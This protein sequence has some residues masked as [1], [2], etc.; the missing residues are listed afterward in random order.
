MKILHIINNLALGGAEKLIEE[1]VPIMNS[2]DRIEVEILLLTD[3][4]NV[5]DKAL[6]SKGIKIHIIGIKKIYSLLNIIK[7]K[8]FIQN[9]RYN[10][11]H[12][13]LF[14]TQYWVAL[15]KPIFTRME[16]P[17]FVTTEHSTFNRR[18]EKFYFKFIDMLIYKRYDC[19]ISI[20]NKVQQNLL[21]WI[22]PKK[23]HI[24]KYK[25]IE[26]GINIEKFIKAVS[27]NKDE[28]NKI[29]TDKTKLLCMVGRFVEAKDQGTII[30]AMTKIDEDIHVIFVGDGILR[31][32]YE[33]MVMQLGLINRV[34]FLGFRND[35]ERILKTVDIVI[36]SSHWEGLSLASIEGMA[37]G[38][39][40]IASKV[41][42][43]KEMVEG[44]G[45]MFEHENDNELSDLV[46][47]LFSN[48]DI[49]NRTSEKCLERAKNYDVKNMVDK[50]LYEYNRLLMLKSYNK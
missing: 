3:K 8:K 25:V 9:G 15:A 17:L 32:K 24:D 48:E 46:K 45:L 31:Q 37:C 35:I 43:L 27:Y 41:Q 5:F 40:F 26:N 14:P 12:S 38:K 29:F 6:I 30:R 20:T 10:I 50:L 34:H 16:V 28:I 39:P 49:Y 2:I 47:L 36:L 33:E 21:K 7:I 44:Y 1:F 19:I 23:E 13:H 11:V 4:D 42:G 22:D 18:R